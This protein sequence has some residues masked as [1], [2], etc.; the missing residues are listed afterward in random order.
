MIKF[1]VFLVILFIIHIFCGFICVYKL[2]HTSK[3]FNF[4]DLILLSIVGPY[5]ILIWLIGDFYYWC[6]SKFKNKKNA[7]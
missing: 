1:L 5:I 2:L 3:S 7:V 4:G 6:Y